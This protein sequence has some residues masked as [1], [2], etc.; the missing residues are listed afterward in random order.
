MSSLWDSTFAFLHRLRYFLLID[1]MVFFSAYKLNSSLKFCLNDS[2]TSLA[3]RGF[4]I[5]ELSIKYFITK[6]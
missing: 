4:E 6:L 1:A 2:S 5:G 3:E